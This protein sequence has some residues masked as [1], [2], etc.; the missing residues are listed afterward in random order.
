M[1]TKSGFQKSGRNGLTEWLPRCVS[2][3]L[4]DLHQVLCNDR[5]VKI[6]E[7]PLPR[8]GSVFC[9]SR[10]VGVVH[11]A[12]A[13]HIDSRHSDTRTIHEYII[14]KWLLINATLPATDFLPQLDVARV[15][16]HCGFGCPTADFRLPENTSRVEARDNPIGDAVGEVNGKMVGFMLLQSDGYL[17]CL[18][19]HD[20]SDVKHPYGL[21]DVSSLR[22]WDANPNS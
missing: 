3:L 9:Q 21:P 2:G 1:P 15:S 6:I 18:E 13:E 7:R 22:P 10:K 11:S 8:M 20:L 19:I 5:A 14:A 4:E 16:G 12:Q 17:R